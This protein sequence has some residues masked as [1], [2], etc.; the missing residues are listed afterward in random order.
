MSNLW[1]LRGVI[2]E[3]RGTD[4][5]QLMLVYG[6][7]MDMSELIGSDVYSFGFQRLGYQSPMSFSISGRGNGLTVPAPIMRSA[8][9][10]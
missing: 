1:V 2:V 7:Y 5:D 10:D 4:N 8:T 3:N 6:F 9:I